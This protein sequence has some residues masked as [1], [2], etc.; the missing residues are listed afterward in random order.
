MLGGPVAGLLN[1]DDDSFSD[2]GSK[3]AQAIE[4]VEEPSG[5]ATQ[6]DVLVLVDTEDTQ[7]IG[8]AR[9]VLEDE[10]DVGLVVGGPGTAYQQVNE[11][12]ENDLIRAELIAF[13]LLFLASLWVFCSAVAA[14]LPLLVGGLTVLGALMVI[15]G[16]N[17][18][19]DISIFALNLITGL[20]SAELAASRRGRGSGRLPRLLVPVVALRHAVPH[21]RTGVRRGQP[22][23]GGPV[24][25]A[26]TSVQYSCVRGSPHST[27][28]RS[29]VG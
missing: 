23:W 5:L 1:V 10:P 21:R 2:T 19:L 9:R 13:P 17:E 8:S 16:I 20:R 26:W 12:V 25:G 4:R 11:Q 27:R 14:L 3:S 24:L 18:V 7:A 6:P 22:H 29:A 28:P 15:R